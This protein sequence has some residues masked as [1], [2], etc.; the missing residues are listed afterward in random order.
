MKNGIKTTRQNIRIRSKR[1]ILAKLIMQFTFTL[2]SKDN[3]EVLLSLKIACFKQILLSIMIHLI[4]LLNDFVVCHIV[5]ITSDL[6]WL[7]V[8]WRHINL[9]WKLL[10]M[11]FRDKNKI[12]PF[13]L[14]PF[15]FRPEWDL[16]R[17]LMLRP[18]SKYSWMVYP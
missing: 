12:I 3:L 16:Q 10:K 17:T 13:T 8:S 5:L 4:F 7:E 15:E 14:Q 1:D 9:E 11:K 6:C 18:L 2:I